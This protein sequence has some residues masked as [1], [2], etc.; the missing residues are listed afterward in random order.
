MS[1]SR[2]LAYVLLSGAASG[3]SRRRPLFGLG[4][5][6]GGPPF[7]AGPSFLVEILLVLVL[8]LVLVIAQPSTPPELKHASL[9]T[10]NVCPTA[11]SRPTLLTRAPSWASPPI[12]P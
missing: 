3:P 8:V 4:W 12:C 5:V 10:S 11:P 1:R 9:T 7:N 6:G 2:F